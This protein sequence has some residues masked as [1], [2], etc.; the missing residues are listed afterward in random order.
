MQ[1]MDGDAVQLAAAGNGALTDGKFV[2][3]AKAFER[4]IEL[5]PSRC[6]FHYWLGDALHKRWQQKFRPH[7][8]KGRSVLHWKRIC[9]DR[10]NLHTMHDWNAGLEQDRQEQDVTTA[11]L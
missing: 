10:T 3:A 4:A 5:D 6:E 8:A 9:D 7:S 11:R 1:D 2:V